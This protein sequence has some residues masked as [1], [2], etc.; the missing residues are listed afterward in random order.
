MKQQ[1]FSLVGD[2]ER[3]AADAQIKHLQREIRYD[4]KD[5][6]IDY[7]I[8]EF[9]KN[10]FYIP[11]YQRE[12]IWKDENKSG[13]IESVLL[14]LPIPLMFF[15][16]IDDGRFEIV[17][18][19][20]RIQTL[21]Q[22]LNNDFEL[23]SL[24]KL[25]TLKG[26]K[27]LDLPVPQQ[28]KLESRSLRTVILEDSTTLDL[29]YEIFRRINTS[30][31]KARASEVRRGAYAGPFMRFV[32]DCANND[33][34]KRLCPVSKSMQL[35]Q[36]P[37][38]LILRF[39]AYSDQYHRFRHD[40]Q[41]FL[42]DYVE[43]CQSTFDKERMSIEFTR[44]LAFVDR[45]IPSGFA[46]ES[47]SATTPRVRFEAISVGVNLAL[48]HQQNLHPQSMSWLNSDAFAKHTTTHAS[49]SLPRLKGRVEF[50]RD[51]LLEKQDT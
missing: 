48:R 40:V 38:E 1:T 26:F 16:Q 21:E 18:G 25:D 29:R 27:F 17:D 2:Q 28:R 9:R 33:L 32:A 4:T 36:E 39:F 11:Q 12:F 13:F 50:V 31:E 19:A 43:T 42:D 20:Q 5:W 46:K 23:G 15:A 8:T 7:L 35:R 51:A 34:F 22:F 6:T 45:Y 47:D 10:R 41:K 30:G 37:E 14:G 3:S 49:N 24:R 44:M